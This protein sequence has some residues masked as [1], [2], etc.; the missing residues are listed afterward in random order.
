M[1]AIN[2]IFVTIVSTI[3][4]LIGIVS[5]SI[6]KWLDGMVGDVFIKEK[7][8]PRCGE[9]HPLICKQAILCPQCKYEV[10]MEEYEDDEDDGIPDDGPHPNNPMFR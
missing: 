1:K 7:I 4:M 9:V 5:H 6:T 2:S 8:C 3:S 10:D